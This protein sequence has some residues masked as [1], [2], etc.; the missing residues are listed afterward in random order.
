MRQGA[1]YM[2]ERLSQSG[3]RDQHCRFR[4]SNGESAV[5]MQASTQEHALLQCRHMASSNEV[6]KLCCLLP[7]CSV[8]QLRFAD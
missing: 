4:F 5:P 8:L 7:A 6:G 3:T 2:G 1:P